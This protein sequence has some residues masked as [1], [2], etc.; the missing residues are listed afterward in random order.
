MTMNVAS[1]PTWVQFVVWALCGAATAVG[2]LAA[3]TIGPLVLVGAMLLAGLALRLG[4]ANRSA[5]GTGAGVGLPFLWVAWLNRGGPGT[6]CTT[7]G[8]G[9][10]CD[11]EWSPWPWLAVGLLMILVCTVLYVLARRR[12]PRS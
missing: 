10:S 4:G 2:L 7:T 8:S 3:F 12:V 11:Q 6:V 5:V 9:R 1:K